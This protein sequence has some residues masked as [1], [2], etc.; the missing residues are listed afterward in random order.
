[1]ELSRAQ[2]H[3]AFEAPDG[4]T[5]G[6]SGTWYLYVVERTEEGDFQVLPIEN[7]V[8]VAGKWILSGQSWREIAV[9]PRRIGADGNSQR[10]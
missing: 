8:H 5:S 10:Q 1:M 2:V 9:D 6:G 3:K 4:R 7:P